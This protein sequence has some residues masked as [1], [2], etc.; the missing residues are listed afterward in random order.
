MCEVPR[1]ILFDSEWDVALGIND[2]ARRK[3]LQRPECSGTFLTR[4][5][6]SPL[7]ST[8]S[9]YCRAEAWPPE[10]PPSALI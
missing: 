6:A 4:Q 10:Y 1:K 9:G 8:T 3:L 2:R 7:I 5:A